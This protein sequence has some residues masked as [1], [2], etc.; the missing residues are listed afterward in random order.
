MDVVRATVLILATL[1]TGHVA[2]LFWAYA[3]S[4]M[5][6]LARADD[7]A[8]IDVMQKINRV[9]LNLWFGAGYFGSALLTALGVV[10]YVGAPNK[11]PL[12]P[13]AVAFVAYLAQMTITRRINIPLNIQLDRAGPVDRISDLTAVRQRF[14]VPWVRW[15]KIRTA[16]S[17]ASF[18]SMCVALA[19]M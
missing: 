9:I 15:H 7:R 14:E 13:V 6:A 11:A 18:G 10:L 8:F 12:I 5:P 19:L 17:A 3:I 4:G 16:V 1:A 2:G